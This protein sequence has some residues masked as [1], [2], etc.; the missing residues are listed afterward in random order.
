MPKQ[1]TLAAAQAMIEAARKHAEKIRVPMNIAVVDDGANLVAFARMDGAW[2]GSI[3]ISQD[4]AFTARAFDMPTKELAKMSQPGEPLF[5]ITASNDGRVVIFAGG[6]P[7]NVDGRV[8]GAVGVSG[9]R[10]DQD[11]EVAEA[12]AAAFVPASHSSR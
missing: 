1:V 2:L 3:D 8:V 5:G 4:K 10:P 9:G 6:I 7:L 12:G 11:H